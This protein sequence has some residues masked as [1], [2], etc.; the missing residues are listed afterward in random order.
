MLAV[1]AAEPHAG[2]V[3]RQMAAHPQTLT[4]HRAG[5]RVRTGPANQSPG[6]AA[7]TGVLIKL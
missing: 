5:G 2:C 7:A 6:E 4:L 1:P 3:G